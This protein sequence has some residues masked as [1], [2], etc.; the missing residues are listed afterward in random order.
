MSPFH[1]PRSTLPAMIGA[2]IL[3]ARELRAGHPRALP[4][5]LVRRRDADPV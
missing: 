4:L 2:F 1:L 5:L 3:H